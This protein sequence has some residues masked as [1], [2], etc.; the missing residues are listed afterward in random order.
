MT[1]RINELAAHE[2]RVGGYLKGRRTKLDYGLVGDTRVTLQALLPKLKQ[3]ADDKHLKLSLNHYGKA[4]KTLDELAT[5][6]SERKGSHPQF[7]ARAISELAHDDAMAPREVQRGDVTR[8]VTA[9]RNLAAGLD[10]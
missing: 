5:E 9:E 1:N 4:R 2:N 10:L 8:G 6:G 7:V 3:N